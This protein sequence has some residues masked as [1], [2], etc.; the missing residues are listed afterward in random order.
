MK[1]KDEVT[2]GPAQRTSFIHTY[3][4]AV[5]MVMCW[6]VALVLVFFCWLVLDPSP[7]G[8]SYGK[9]YSAVDFLAKV[10]SW[11]SVPVALFL[12]LKKIRHWS[13]WL[14]VLSL[15]FFLYG[16]WVW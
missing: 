5:V 2:R 13:G 6:P 8:S 7:L 4:P 11:A 16:A 14:Y 1:T 9:L 15:G 12:Y 10:I 3:F